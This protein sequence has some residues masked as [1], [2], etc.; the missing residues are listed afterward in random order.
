MESR[1]FALITGLFVLGITACI[2]LW[3]QWLA[4]VPLART[5]YRVVS[6]VPVSG[7][8]PE[9]QVRYRGMSVGRVTAHIS[10]RKRAGRG[11]DREGRHRHRSSRRQSVQ[12]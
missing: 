11:R 12:R 4:K 7:L 1:A 5:P 3:A 2:I 6:M 9:A 10:P 8:N